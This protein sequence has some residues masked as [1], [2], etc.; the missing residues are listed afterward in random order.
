MIEASI[1]LH[2]DDNMFYIGN[3]SGSTARGYRQRALNARGQH[4]RR[5]R[6]CN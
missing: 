2:Q 5:R 4:G 6:S 1:F 3:C